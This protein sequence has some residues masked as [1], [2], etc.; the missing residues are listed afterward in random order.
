[1]RIGFGKASRSVKCFNFSSVKTMILKT[2][3]ATAVF[4][5]LATLRQ[6]FY[7]R[8]SFPSVRPPAPIYSRPI[9][10]SYS[11]LV[12]MLIFFR[13]R[14]TLLCGPSCR[15][16]TRLP[17][18][19]LPEPRY[20]ARTLDPSTNHRDRAD[21]TESCSILTVRSTVPFKVLSISI[22]FRS[23]RTSETILFS[24]SDCSLV[25]RS[26]CHVFGHTGNAIRSE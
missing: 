23:G 24:S 20:Q 1:M 3:V 2:P 15:N 4:A 14:P 25:L 7:R 22:L 9:P 8:K 10:P 6:I 26:L 21:S 18:I 16:T 12:W 17:P 5:D 19:S 13:T 11:G